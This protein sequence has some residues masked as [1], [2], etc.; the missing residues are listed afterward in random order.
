MIRTYIYLLLTT[1]L[2]IFL[3]ADNSCST[4]LIALIQGTQIKYQKW[5][6]I[7][8]NLKLVKFLTCRRTFFFSQKLY[9]YSG[10]RCYPESNDIL[11]VNGMKMM[12]GISFF[13]NNCVMIW[14]LV[15]GEYR[16]RPYNEDS[17]QK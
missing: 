6:F 16:N 12:E 13:K 5:L 7:L 10:K 4:T 8:K 17:L 15:A 14:L 9:S 11:F 1:T 3:C 2:L